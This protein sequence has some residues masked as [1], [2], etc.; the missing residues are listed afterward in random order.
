MRAKR[1]YGDYQT[2]EFF[3]KAV[4]TYLKETRKLTP[5]LIIEPTCGKGSFLKSSLIFNAQKIIGIE[6]NPKYCALCAQEINSP[7]VGHC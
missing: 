5:T 7:S 1:E 3:S 6:V 4:C 2:P